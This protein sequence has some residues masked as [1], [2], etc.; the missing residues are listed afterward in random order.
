LKQLINH[1]RTLVLAAFLLLST[2]SA[3]LVLAQTGGASSGGFSLR[4]GF[5]S[6]PAPT[7]APAPAPEPEDASEPGEELAGLAEQ[8][9][10]TAGSQPSYFANPGLLAIWS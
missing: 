2:L 9:P 7:P 5:V 8:S 3:A 4:G 1:E 10:A 6:N